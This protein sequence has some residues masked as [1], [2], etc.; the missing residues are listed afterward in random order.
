MKITAVETVPYSIPYRHPLVFATGELRSADHVLVRVHTDEGLIGI[1]EAVARPMIYGESQA[2]IVAAIRAWCG[3]A[4]VGLDP[5]AVETA[6][7]TLA[8]VVANNTA[9][10]ALD[11]ALH[12]I[13]G[14]AVGQ[15]LWRLLGG[16]S[17]RMRVTR[18]LTMGEPTEVAD[19]ARAAAEQEG[20]TAFKVKVGVDLRTD[21]ARVVAVR[22]AVGD[23]ATIYVDANHGYT[24]E[25]AF[26]ALE[27]IR[28]CRLELVEEPSPAD[29]RIGRLRLAQRLDLPIM[30]DESAATLADATRELSTGAA[31]AVSIKTTR[32]GFTESARILA[33]ARALGA[34][35]LLGNQG[36]SMIGTAA[37]LAFGV[38]HTWIAREPG[39]LDFFTLLTDQ[40][41]QQPLSVRDGALEPTDQPGI[42]VA[43]DDEKLTRYRVDLH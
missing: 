22:R 13:R 26:E 15:P 8:Q 20:I 33:V 21:A 28:E 11:I 41:V 2:S 24:A 4:L 23:D 14:K 25:Q 9:K 27:A 38:A 3:P 35:A 30:A 40:L 34:R 43:I 1:G 12:D 37:A 32:T 5:F 39:E 17:R 29:D 16:T 10:A 18:M 36:D 6:H 42:G 19:E 31:R 7:D